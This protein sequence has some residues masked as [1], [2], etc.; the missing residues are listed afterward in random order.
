MTANEYM[1]KLQQPFPEQDIEWRVQQAGVYKE[2][3]GKSNGWALVL[4]YINNRAIQER[5][6]AVFGIDGWEN[7]FTPLPDGGLI[8]YLK[9]RVGET[10]I[11]KGDGADKTAIEA[12]KGGLSNAMKRSGSQWG[13]GRYLYNLES[14]FVNLYREKG[15]H[16]H[17][18]YDKDT[19]TKYYWTPPKLPEW[20][21]PKGAQ[22]D[23]S[24]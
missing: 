24:N 9:C 23:S 5:L 21:L 16:T 2:P 19:K 1:L 11:R 4:A 13:I 8:C 3:N 7:E 6:D 22:N 18:H 15:N 12:T 17:S 20:A 10:W 14:T